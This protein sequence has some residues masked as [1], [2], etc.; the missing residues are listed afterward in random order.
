MSRLGVPEDII[1]RPGR[2]KGSN[3]KTVVSRGGFSMYG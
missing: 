1:V 2:L 3:T